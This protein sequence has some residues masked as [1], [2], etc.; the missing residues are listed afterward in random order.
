MHTVITYWST[1]EMFFIFCFVGKAVIESEAKQAPETEENRICICRNWL[2][3]DSVIV[4]GTIKC[5]SASGTKSDNDFPS[6]KVTLKS[7]NT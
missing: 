6:L 3:K 2:E 1:E 7:H 5:L 4:A